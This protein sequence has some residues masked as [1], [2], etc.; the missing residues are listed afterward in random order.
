M[1]SKDLKEVENKELSS[2]L[3]SIGYKD[4]LTKD[5]VAIPII[6]IIQKL[7]P[8]LELNPEAKLGMLYNTATSELFNYELNFVPCAFDAKYL[9]RT[10][11]SKGGGFG[12]TFS[13]KP[14]GFDISSEG[15][16]LKAG[17][18]ME[19]VYTHYHAVL[20]DGVDSAIIPMNSTQLKISKKWNVYFRK[21]L[22]PGQPIFMNMFNVRVN[23]QMVRNMPF[24]GW[25]IP[26]NV[27]PTTMNEIKRA[28]EF[29]KFI[30]EISINKVVDTVL[31]EEDGDMSF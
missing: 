17:E 12:G 20:I 26:K 10:P 19:V 16:W 27:R 1:V 28:A 3:E 9:M 31:K 7:S 18:D 4:N 5:D 6:K 15:K 14:E 23:D 22:K 21:D 30:K 29:Y 24:K 2:L 11:L 8:I 13:E 25:D